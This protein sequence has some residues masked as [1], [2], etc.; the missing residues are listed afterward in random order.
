MQ[1]AYTS[2]NKTLR[3]AWAAIAPGSPLTITD[4][5]VADSP[6]NDGLRILWQSEGIP[7]GGVGLFYAQID[8]AMFLQPVAGQPDTQTALV[9]QQ[10]LD[11]AMGFQG[12]AD[13]HGG[14]GTGRLGRYDY[15]VT[16][17]R[18]LSEMTVLAV[19]GWEAIASGS[20]GLIQRARTLRLRYTTSTGA[21]FG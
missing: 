5:A 12:T 13:G 3:A 18:Y 1:H 6:P 4:P 7:A 20:P 15:T 11:L 9:R 10:A 21:P 19:H 16:P 17:A 2:F 14:D 8:L